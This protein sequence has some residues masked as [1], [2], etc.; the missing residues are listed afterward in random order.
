MK[1]LIYLLLTLFCSYSLFSQSDTLDVSNFSNYS[2]NLKEYKEFSKKFD[3]RQTFSF[4]KDFNGN[5]YKIGD[6]FKLGFPQK[7]IGAIENTHFLTI[8]SSDVI[9]SNVDHT[10]IITTLRLP[11]H[12]FSGSE[13][14]IKKIG[15]RKSMGFVT[16]FIVLTCSGIEI[17]TTSIDY[18]ISIKEII[19]LNAPLSSEEALAKLKALKE[20]LDLE[21]IT[22]EEY[23]NQKKEL[24][25]FIK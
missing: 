3:N 25:K 21:L 18:A 15:V 20:K 24:S 19:D 5:I 13:C 22:R 9:S 14:V 8:Y 11:G 10:S 1:N 12:N 6:K 2:N 23:D 16:P 4:I 7:V 17:S